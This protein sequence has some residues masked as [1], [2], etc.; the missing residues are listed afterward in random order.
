MSINRA[1]QIIY[2]ILSE[3]FDIKLTKQKIIIS[4]YKTKL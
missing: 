2:Q 1:I 3:A 4:I